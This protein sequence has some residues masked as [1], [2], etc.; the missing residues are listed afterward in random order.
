MKLIQNNIQH[1]QEVKNLILNLT[2][3]VYATP[4]PV[5][6]GA[7]IGQHFRHIIEFYICLMNGVRKG[8]IC[9]DERERNPLIETK[10][11]YAAKTIDEIVKFLHSINADKLV[12]LK[13]NYSS[14]NDDPE[15]IN[16]FFYRELAYALDHSVHHMALIKIALAKEN[17]HV[18]EEVGVAP[19]TLRYKQHVQ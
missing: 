13:A 7:S 11:N 10:I 18:D 15:T 14:D 1:L 5:L 9:Y 6:N 8:E 3:E 12:V 2:G 16:S 17:I 4:Q 19:S